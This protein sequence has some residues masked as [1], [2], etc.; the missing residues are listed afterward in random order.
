MSK[1]DNLIN[2]HHHSIIITRCP[3]CRGFT[4]KLAEFYEMMKKS[5]KEFEIVFAS[6]D[7]DQSS[8]DSYMKEMPWLAIPFAGRLHYTTLHY[9]TLYYTTLHY[10]TLHYTTL[11]CTTPHHNTPLYTIRYTL[12]TIHYNTIKGDKYSFPA[13]CW[14]VGVIFY[15][16][17]ALDRPFYGKEYVSLVRAVLTS[18][19]S[20]DLPTSYSEEVRLACHTLLAKEPKNRATMTQMLRAQLF[21]PK[22]RSFPSGYRPKV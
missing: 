2:L 14:S 6:S 5:K 1:Q 10:T 15:E 4:P 22:A 8:F 19:P 3:P 13:D 11:H 12:Y 16:L 7:K 18:P 20:P 17:L 9:T 21:L